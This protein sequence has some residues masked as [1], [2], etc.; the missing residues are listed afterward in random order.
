MYKYICIFVYIT[1]YFRFVIFVVYPDI[2]Y[3]SI[4][5][6]CTPHF[7]S[8]FFLTSRKKAWK[9]VLPAGRGIHRFAIFSGRFR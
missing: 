3:I 9:Y 1:S 5:F 8:T 7:R 2:S 6:K 4:T